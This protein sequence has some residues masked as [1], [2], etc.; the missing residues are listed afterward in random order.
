MSEIVET[1]AGPVHLRAAG[2]SVVIATDPEA[3]ILHWGAALDDSDLAALT[4][5]STGG[6]SYSS[7]DAPRLFP[8]LATERSGWSGRPAL[9]WHR[10]GQHSDPAPVLTATDRTGAETVVFS[11]EDAAAQASVD[12]TLHLDPFGILR[13]RVR[14][15]STAEA[16]EPL[17]LI[18]VRA[19]VPLPTE[20]DEILDFT[21][22]WTGE[23]R[24]QRTPITFGAHVRENRRGRTGHD[25][26]FVT[27]TGSEGFGFRTGRV[28]ACHT[29]WSGNL[30]TA[31]ERLPEGAGV[32]AT[33]LSAGELLLAGE[34]RLAPGQ[35]YESPE[36]LLIFS[37]DGIDGLSARLHGAVRSMPSYPASPRPL[38]LNTWEAVYFDHDPEKLGELARTAASV[39]V[40]RFVLDDG[41]F[42]G[43]P[44]DRSGLGDWTIDTDAWPDGLRG[45]SDLVHGF[46]MQF[47][48]WFEPE[49]VNPDSD[50]ARAHPEWI[51][52]TAP[53]QAGSEQARP[54]QATWRH[55]LVLDL[56]QPTAW[57][58][59]L[60]RM[61]DVIG[62]NAVDFVKWDHNRDLHAAV[63]RA[64]GRPAVHDQV[65]A[66]YALMDELRRR[67]PGLEIESCASGGARVDLGVLSHAQRVW[68]SDTND[69]IERQLIQRFTGVLLPPEI[70][71]SHVGPARAHTTHRTAS[72]S[73]RMLTALFG[74]AGI[75]W[76]I[77]SCTDDERQALRGWSE[78][79]RE[80]RPLLHAGVTVRADGADA[81]A[82]LH[83]VVS[84]SRDHAVFAWVRLA[85][86][87]S[88]GA[89]RVRIP[90]LDPEAT[91]VVRER[92]ELGGSDLHLVRAPAW[93]DAPLTASGRL[94]GEAGLPM[95][96]LNP[97]SATLLEFTRLT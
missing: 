90:G 80:L 91:Y 29:A 14:V 6:V 76:D 77:T 61:D 21:G 28:W 65:L 5:T 70:V 36:T 34:M 22:R 53:N 46:G 32:H 39:G 86:S 75:E 92:T 23:R 31:V 8:L 57:N 66:A 45:L 78:L 13:H 73:F 58:H 84:P 81:G 87:T 2:V 51:L 26:A 11:F 82:L 94:L 79:Y 89:M 12:L 42:R 3:R 17:A 35:S 88:G 50:L 62:T 72:L 59:I 33:A 69:P 38:V 25:A 41:W 71:G 95:P 7:F 55:Q 48:I 24:A 37:A 49:M 20:V 74:H 16:G 44:D 40:E 83:G 56:T 52:G 47:G 68:A 18:A 54:E 4:F 27:I 63:S 93:M 67:H 19:L 30:D 9:E 43:R 60:E 96:V 15:T 85:P 1:F 97:G 64:N 10:G